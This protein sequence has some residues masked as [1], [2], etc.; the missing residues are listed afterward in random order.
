MSSNDPDMQDFPIHDF[1]PKNLPGELLQRVDLVILQANALEQ[2]IQEAIAAM[3]GV[4]FE[5][6]KAVT[7]HMNMPLRYGVL[8]STAE[9]RID[10][11]DQ[12]DHLDDLIQRAENA[13][14]KRNAFAHREWY[15][16]ADGRGTFTVEET[17]RTRLEVDVEKVEASDF[18]AAHEE[19]RGVL[20]DFV[21]FMKWNGLEPI[22][23]DQFRPRAHKSKAARKSRRSQRVT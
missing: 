16:D 4:D 10:D 5:Y 6:G 1:D 18:K 2:I 8:R 17:S 12:L 11:L 22:F 21:A 7:T 13:F 19:I 23:P 3:L 20:F 15:T 14:Q 9:I